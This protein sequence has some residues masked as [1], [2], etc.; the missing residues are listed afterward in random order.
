MMLIS[1]IL[2]FHLLRHVTGFHR[3]HHKY[4]MILIRDMVK[5]FP[6]GDLEPMAGPTRLPHDH[7]I[8]VYYCMQFFF[9]LIF[10]ILSWKINYNFTTTTTT[11][12]AGSLPR[13]NTG[14]GLYPT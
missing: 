14:L 13:L 1:F 6:L 3:S 10:T 8:F 9:N 2:Q 7:T 12:K 11:L 5:L 4:S